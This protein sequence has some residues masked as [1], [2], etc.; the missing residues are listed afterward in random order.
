MAGLALVSHVGGQT[1]I[2]FALAK[3]P[4]PVA[5]VT[6]LIQPVTATLAAATLLGESVVWVQVLGMALVLAGVFVA[7]QEA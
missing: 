1:L 7:R 4:A 2:A 6:L 3:L 5:S